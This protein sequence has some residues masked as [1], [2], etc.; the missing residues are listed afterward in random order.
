ME[1]SGATLFLNRVGATCHLMVRSPR[2]IRWTRI[3][4][5]RAKGHA[6]SG[7]LGRECEC[8]RLVAGRATINAIEFAIASARARDSERECAIAR[9]SERARG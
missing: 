3:K 5:F 7:C 9:A 2:S 1:K 6:V 8:E 4:H